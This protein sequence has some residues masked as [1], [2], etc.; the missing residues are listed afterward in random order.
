MNKRRAETSLKKIYLSLYCKVACERELETEQNCNILTPTLMAI[1]VVSFS[2]SWCSTRGP[3][4]HFAGFLYYCIL[5]PTGMVSKLD[6]GPEGHFCW[7]VAFPTTSF[8]QLVCLQLTDFLSLPSYIIDQ[9]P[10]QS[11]EWHV[12]SSSSGNNCHAVQRNSLPVHQSMSVP[13]DFNPVPHRQPS[14]PTPMEHAT[15][16]SLEWHVWPVRRS[17]YNTEA[18]FPRKY[19]MKYFIEF[20]SGRS[21]AEIPLLI[22]W[23]DAPMH[24]IKCHPH[25]SIWRIFKTYPVS[26]ESVTLL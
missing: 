13:W 18:V 26:V 25:L 1:S 21:T 15:S 16:A 5:S 4:A 12:W 7:V 8:L 10:T 17:I 19:K 23:V 2:F 6:R 14:S 3:G 24:L 20:S 22:W 9:S 11:L